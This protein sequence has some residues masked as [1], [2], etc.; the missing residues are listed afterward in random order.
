MP[1]PPAGLTST[2]SIQE[3][4]ASANG[5]FLLAPGVYS[6]QLKLKSQKIYGGPGVILEAQIVSVPGA[7]N[8]YVAGIEVRGSKAGRIGVFS[9]EGTG[10]V[11][12]YMYVHDI[13]DPSYGGPGSANLR[14]TCVH[15]GSN[16]HNTLRNSVITRCGEIGVIAQEPSDRVINNE[17]SY[18][19]TRNF[20]WNIPPGAAAG[21]KSHRSPGVV[22]RNNWLHHNKAPSI[23]IDATPNSGVVIERNLIESGTAPGIMYE[24]SSGGRIDTNVIRNT[25]HAGIYISESWNATI[26]NNKLDSNHGSLIIVEGGR[27]Q[28][29][30]DLTFTNNHVEQDNEGSGSYPLA[31]GLIGTPTANPNISFSNNTYSIASGIAKPFRWSGKAKTPDQWT[32]I[33]PNDMV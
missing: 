6:T 31:A 17:I 24:I 12:D 1:S 5:S 26:V 11:F 19:N 3:I 28:V 15:L 32:T 33:H 27:S 30:K 8:A 16:G 22:Y 23:W 9:V 14:P 18:A 20:G 29:A 4:N 10:M 2:S 7:G 13:D 25:S 21:A